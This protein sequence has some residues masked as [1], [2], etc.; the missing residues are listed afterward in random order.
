MSS[1]ITTPGRSLGSSI[2]QVR[3]KWGWFVA[4]GIAMLICGGIAIGN[5]VLAT[6]VS[7]YW[8]GALM[9]VAG[10]VEIVHAFGVKTWG[11]FFYWLLSGILYALAGVFAFIN[12]LLATAVLTFLLAI[13]LIASG[14]L[15]IFIGFGQRGEKG[16]GWIVAAGVVTALAGVVIAI[17]WPVNSL[18]IL[19][20]FLAVDLIF[21]GWSYIALG[22]GLR[23]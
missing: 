17:H 18:W 19:G 6:L 2:E 22:L 9:L 12:P 1:D 3:S 15:R 23:R 11:R 16:W 20:M 8:V 4:L 21:Q 14:V 7:I 10:I 5:L 13:A